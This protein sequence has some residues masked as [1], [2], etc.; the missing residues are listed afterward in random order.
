QQT[1]DD[2]KVQDDSKHEL[3]SRRPIFGLGGN[4]VGRG[5]GVWV[6][7]WAGFGQGFG[8]QLVL[9][10]IVLGGYAA[11]APRPVHGIDVGIEEHLVEVPHQDGQRR[12]D[13]LVKVHGGGGVD[14]PAGEQVADRHLEI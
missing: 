14:P 5:W 12:Q 13:G 8:V 2:N 4:V 9:V 1:Q 7:I 6:G 11:V 10:A 3:L